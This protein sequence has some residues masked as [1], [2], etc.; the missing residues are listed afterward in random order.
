MTRAAAT[1]SEL[2]RQRDALARFERYLPTLRLKARQLQ[3]EVHRV[4]AQLRE[5]D[6][7]ETVVRRELS[8]WITLWS[9]PVDFGGYRVL[10]DVALGTVNVAG[11]DVPRLERVS[12]RRVEP[13]PEGTPTWFDEAVAV[14]ERLAEL[15]LRRRVLEAG[16]DRLVQELRITTQR[17]N[18]FERVQI[19]A[20]REAMRSIRIVLGD[21]Q[22]AAVVR[23][24][25]A[26]SKTR[27]PQADA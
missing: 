11:V 26:K 10:E 2:K 12:W 8:A 17:I 18:L 15:R 14:L 27:D 1:P 3:L 25:I 20:A 6:A 19:P 5:V 13:D 23:A 22:A 16:R 24:K 21:R 4:E 9:D 7:D